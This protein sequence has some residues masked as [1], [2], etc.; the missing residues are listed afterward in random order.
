MD[1]NV[2]LLHVCPFSRYNFT[3]FWLFK[4]CSLDISQAKNPNR[5]VE[6]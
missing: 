6:Q 1:K 4:N 3:N 2:T 5:H